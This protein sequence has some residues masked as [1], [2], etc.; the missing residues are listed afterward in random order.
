MCILACSRVMSDRNGLIGNRKG[1]IICSLLV[2][3]EML[4]FENYNYYE[5]NYNY[6]NINNV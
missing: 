6:K 2:G 1:Q 3:I 5:K 4:R